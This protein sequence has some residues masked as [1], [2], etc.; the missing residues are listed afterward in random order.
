MINIAVDFLSEKIKPLPFVERYGGLV[1][2]A[3]RLIDTSDNDTPNMTRQSF[4]VS[5]N[6]S[7]KEC[8]DNERY[9]DLAPNSNYSSVFYIEQLLPLSNSGF[10]KQKYAKFTVNTWQSQLKLVGWLNMPR[11]GYSDCSISP[12]VIQHVL[13]AIDTNKFGSLPTSNDGVRVSIRPQQILTHDQRIFQGYTYQDR[14]DLLFEPYDAFAII[15]DIQLHIQSGCLPDFDVLDDI[16][17]VDLSLPYGL[18]E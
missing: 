15:I 9:N 5:C 4:P 6:I 13:K 2:R 3:E 18:V 7:D 17:C 8:W 12:A 16:S 10:N 14:T 1:R 11:L